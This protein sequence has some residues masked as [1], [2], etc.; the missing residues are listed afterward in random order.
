MD[1]YNYW[2]NV[3]TAYEINLK[4]NVGHTPSIR[5]LLE[6]INKKLEKLCTDNN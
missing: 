6:K 5:L 4:N 3:K 1:S 2:I